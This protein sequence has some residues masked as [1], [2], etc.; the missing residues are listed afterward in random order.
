MPRVCIVCQSAKRSEIDQLLINGEA[1]RSIAK[2][3]D[4]GESAVYRHQKGHL[5]KSLVRA[6]QA[7]QEANA[8]SLIDQVQALRAKAQ[9]I[10]ERA[11]RTGSLDVALKGIRKLRGL[12]ELMGQL[13]GELQ[14]GTRIGIAVGRGSSASPDSLHVVFVEPGDPYLEVLAQL[15]EGDRTA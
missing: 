9:R 5:V 15:G 6:K 8:D 7:E 10:T 3:F 14:K 13:N 1:Y 12:V 2:R 11:E 4:I